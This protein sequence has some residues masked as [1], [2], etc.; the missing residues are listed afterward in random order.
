MQFRSVLR[1][2]WFALLVEALPDRC[3]LWNIASTFTRR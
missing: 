1:F 3:I 2:S